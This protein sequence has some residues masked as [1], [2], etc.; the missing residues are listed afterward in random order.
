MAS[1]KQ[2]NTYIL[3]VEGETERW[4]FE[5]VQRLI[6][7]CEQADFHV[8]FTI[9]KGS[10]KAAF[11][12]Y[13]NVFKEPRYFHIFDYEGD[14]PEFRTNFD[15]TLRQLNEINKQTGGNKKKTYRIGYSNL[16][17][18]LWILLHKTDFMTCLS[19]RS[20]YLPHI[21]KVYHRSFKN[22]EDYKKEQHFKSYIL[23]QITLSDVQ[24]AIMRAKRIR[25]FNQHHKTPGQ[26]FGFTYFK[27]NPD[28]TLHDCV[29]AILAACGI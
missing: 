9:K 4:Y 20:Q 13:P 15:T 10:P 17:F 18:E 22:T 11:S 5:H 7:L 6:N 25:E 1:R 19:D 24:A 16:T 8:S 26:A 23:E 21:C 3:S 12:A 29:S 27:D 14:T 28:L 2:C